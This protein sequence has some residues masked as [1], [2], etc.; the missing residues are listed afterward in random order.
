MFINPFVSHIPS[1]YLKV[2]K[3]LHKSTSAF[4]L[5]SNEVL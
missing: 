1:F 4:F 3:N 2:R 5:L